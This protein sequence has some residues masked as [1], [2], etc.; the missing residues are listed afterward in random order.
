M[1][2]SEESNLRIE[3]DWYKSKVMYRTDLWFELALIE[4]MEEEVR[5]QKDSVYTSATM[6]SKELFSLQRKVEYEWREKIM[7]VFFNGIFG[8]F[9]SIVCKCIDGVLLSYFW[10]GF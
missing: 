4:V 6:K 9:R 7:T 10:F 2:N 5:C 3:E 1:C 8:C